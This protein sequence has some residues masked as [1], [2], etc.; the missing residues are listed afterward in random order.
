[1]DENVYKIKISPEVI[2]DDIFKV[3]YPS[4]ATFDSGCTYV[5]SGMSYVLSGGTGGA[6]LLTGLTIPILITQTATDVG[7]YS[8]FDGDLLQSDVVNNFIFSA[9]TQ[10]PNRVYFYNTSD[11]NYKNYLQ[12][13]SFKVDW[14]DNT[15]DIITTTSPNYLYHDYLDYGNYTISLTQTLPWGVNEVKKQ[16]VIPYTGI[17]I[18]NPS[19]TVYFT[20]TTGSWSGSP[21]YY[22]YI[23]TGDS[24]NSIINQIT[25]SYITTPFIITGNTASRINELRS[26]GP[27]PFILHKQIVDNSGN[28]FG[29]IDSIT[30]GYTGYTIHDTRYID[31]LNGGTVYLVDSYGLIEEW[32]V[33]EPIVKDESLLNIVSDP[34]VQSDIYIERGKNS[35]LERIE[36]LGE[37]SNIGDL[38]QYGYGFFKFVKQE[39]N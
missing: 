20:A 37:V 1:M 15:S 3:C 38:E 27:I 4:G 12:L 22:D 23:F 7:Y 31:I 5:Y 32:M 28:L 10:I 30:S 11:V 26:Y 19:G 14:G 35:A 21:S 16:V 17:T 25:S 24:E 36:R 13:A 39:N 2:S 34:E 18:D 33:A 29:V 8:T 9:V 6:S